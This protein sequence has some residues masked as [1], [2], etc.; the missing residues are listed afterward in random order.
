MVFTNLNINEPDWRLA[1]P[2]EGS[3]AV[4]NVLQ[5][6]M[7]G[8]T[9]RSSALAMYWEVPC[10]DRTTRMDNDEGTAAVERMAHVEEGVGLNQCRGTM[11]DHVYPN[12]LELN[13]MSF[14]C[15]RLDYY[16]CLCGT[17]DSGHS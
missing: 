12:C 8:L 5:L 14:N 13:K 1:K 2:I 11:C 16:F 10:C 17:Y 3:L 6:I 9:R 15:V 7:C 4:C